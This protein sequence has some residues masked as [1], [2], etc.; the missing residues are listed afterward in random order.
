MSPVYLSLAQI[1]TLERWAGELVRAGQVEG[2]GLDQIPV[3]PADLGEGWI[4]LKLPAWVG[5]NLGT[6]ER[7]ISPSGEGFRWSDNRAELVPAGWL[8]I[9]GSYSV[10]SA[11]ERVTRHYAY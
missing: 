3:E 7:Y 6:Y 4:R 11:G 5:L 8:P 1:R 2:F 9:L 10:R